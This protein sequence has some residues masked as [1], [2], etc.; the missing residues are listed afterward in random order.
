[1]SLHT[2]DGEPLRLLRTGDSFMLRIAYE[3]D[4]EIVVPSFVVRFKA[5][6][7]QEIFRLSTVPISGYIIPRLGARGCVELTV[8]SLPVTGGQYYM[9]V[10]LVAQRVERLV[11]LDDVITLEV[12][13]N[14]VMAAG[15]P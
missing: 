4:P 9:D 14:D 2:V 12:T 1:M 11:Q 7:G 3:A 13:E 8:E 5:I 15:W 10:R 6:L